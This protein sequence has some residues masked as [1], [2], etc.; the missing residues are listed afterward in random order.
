MTR[1][2]MYNNFQTLKNSGKTFSNSK[3][4]NEVASNLDFWADATEHG[5]NNL[6]DTD[7]PH[8]LLTYCIVTIEEAREL[9]EPLQLSVYKVISMF[10]NT[11]TLI[12][13]EPKPLED[14]TISQPT[15]DFAE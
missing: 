13:I 5:L 2:E 6:L 3:L 12:V 14:A 8:L 11:A 4:F 15:S 1:R 9:L 7:I 10:D